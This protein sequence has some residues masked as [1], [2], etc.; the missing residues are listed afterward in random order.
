MTEENYQLAL[1]DFRRARQEAALRQLLHRLTG[2]E[3]HLL[4][5]REIADKLS[6]TG[7]IERG[8]Q[9]IPLVDIIGSVGRA[10]DFT[11]EFLPKR[12][13]D[14][15]RWARVKTAVLDMKGWPPIEVYKL[16]GAYFVKDG[17]HRVSVARQLGNKTI[18]AYVTEVKTRLPLE[19]DADPEEIINKTY[20]LQ[21]LEVT[22]L[23]ES[24][25]GADLSLSFCNQYSS[26]L[27]QIDHYKSNLE[28]WE[29]RD[30]SFKDAAARWYD[31]VYLPIAK[32]IIDQG[33]LREFP[34]YTEADIYV[35]LSEKREQLAEALGWD[36]RANKAVIA[37]SEG[38]QGGS[39]ST[40]A[41]LGGRLMGRASQEQVEGPPPGEWRRQLGASIR[42]GFLFNDILVSIQ[43]TEADWH[44]LQESI[45][46]AQ[47]E[48]G[49]IMAIHAVDKEDELGNLETN[50]IAAVF[51][52]KCTDVGIEGQFAAEVGNEGHLMLKRA[53][54]VD[55]VATNLTF[56]TE[57]FTESILSSGVRKLI[58]KCPRPILV[59]P[60]LVNSP[61]DYAL[62]GYD[63]SPKADEAL[64]VATYLALRW[65]M[66]LAIVTVCTKFTTNL[67]LERA[68]GYLAGHHIV[69]AD[70]FLK[71]GPITEAILETAES[72]GCNLII[73]GGFGQRPVRNLKLGSTV[74]GVLKS[75]NYPVLIC[76]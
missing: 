34:G 58:Q 30:L 5:Y 17:N 12:D 33:T 28:Q 60:S 65:Q 64:F 31:E 35:L 10:D 59:I 49:R 38:L 41:K 25:P 3:D 18:S 39:Q 9:E 20:Y 13:S 62:L 40:L 11:R 75:Y 27:R 26:L 71:E 72:Q 48:Q 44:L 37:L 63:G 2:R 7:T 53:S 1:K 46:I 70:F 8:V 42:E 47:K 16:G 23:N 15:E 24:K 29:N 36:I 52:K 69:N 51:K 61:M 50:E 68:K 76:R 73:V 19:S 14:A 22:R 54:W 6:I 45:R 66:R 57:N 43:G 74:D 4:A 67:A 56:A 55:L 21:F 32:H